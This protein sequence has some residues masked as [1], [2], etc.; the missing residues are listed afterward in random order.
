M[1]QNTAPY[2]IKV[3]LVQDFILSTN[4]YND[5][6]FVSLFAFF[7]KVREITKLLTNDCKDVLTDVF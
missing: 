2:C 4:H 5:H 1:H 7:N 3:C 6:I